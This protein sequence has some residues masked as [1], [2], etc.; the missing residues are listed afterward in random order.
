MVA[1]SRLPAI[2]LT[3]PPEQSARF[4]QALLAAWPGLRVVISPIL[5]P[6]FISPALPNVAFGTLILTSE[7]GVEAARRIAAEGRVLPRSAFCVGDRTARAAQA[8]GF[9]ATSA[10]G[11]AEALLAL[12]LARKP[13]TPLLHIH[14]RETRGELFERLNSAG[15]ETISA[16]GYEQNLQPLTP[17]AEELLRSGRPVLAPVFSPRSAQALADECARVGATSPLTIAAIS[18]AAAAPFAQS[19]VLLAT[20]PDAAMLMQV[21]VS[22]LASLNL[23]PSQH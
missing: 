13:D 18:A 3:R 5:A 8:A 14:G 2:L 6:Y 19:D 4:A 21:I 16:I 12:I 10:S 7:T 15:I 11:D 9:A 23:P 1:Q 17:E 22:R 20:H